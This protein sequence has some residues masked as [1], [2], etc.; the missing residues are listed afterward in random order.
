MENIDNLDKIIIIGQDPYKGN[1]NY[2]K[3]FIS[4]EYL[5]KFSRY[6]SIIGEEAFRRGFVMAFTP[7]LGRNRR[8]NRKCHY[9]KK[10]IIFVIWKR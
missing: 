7:P 1:A 10:S 3:L 2:K 9:P 8:Y 4:G 6:Q 5:D